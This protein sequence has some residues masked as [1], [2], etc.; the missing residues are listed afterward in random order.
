VRF[1]LDCAGAVTPDF[2]G[3]LPG[4][5]A[6]VTAT[7]E[8]VDLAVKKGAFARSFRSDATAPADLAARVEAGLTKAALNALGLCRRTGAAAVGFDQ[9]KQLL[10]GGKA[11]ALISAADGAEDGKRK[12]KALARGAVRFEFFEGCELSAALGRDGVV[13]VALKGGPA[14]NRFIREA[15]RLDGF[16]S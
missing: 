16:R 4:R 15:R 10:R 9:A 11:A 7:R 2:S 8:A 5:G 14:A 13:H 12:L 3:K 1:V 6:W